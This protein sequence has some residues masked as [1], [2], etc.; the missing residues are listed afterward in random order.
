MAVKNKATECGHTDKPLYARGLCK[1]WY[2]SKY[3]EKIYNGS[4]VPNMN[5][6]AKKLSHTS[7]QKEP[8]D[9]EKIFSTNM[10]DGVGSGNTTNEKTLE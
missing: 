1:Q 4:Y 5:R 7:S 8:Q 10:S 2:L 9:S 3:K 6:K